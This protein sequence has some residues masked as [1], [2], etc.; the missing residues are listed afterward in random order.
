MLEKRVLIKR[1]ACFV[2]FYL[3]SPDTILHVPRNN[4][5]CM[6]IYSTFHYA[7]GLIPPVHL[8]VL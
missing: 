3:F 2:H 5:Y 8:N 7:A 6:Q 4:L 1:R